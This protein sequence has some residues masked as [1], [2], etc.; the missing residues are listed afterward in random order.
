[1]DFFDIHTYKIRSL[2]E[3]KE[4]I[5]IPIELS[6]SKKQKNDRSDPNHADAPSTIMSYYNP[7]FD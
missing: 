2:A 6:G 5:I 3:A 7:S 4:R 1:M